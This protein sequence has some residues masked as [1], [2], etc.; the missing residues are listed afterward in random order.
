MIFFKLSTVTAGLLSA[1]NI[2]SDVTGLTPDNKLTKDSHQ[3]LSEENMYLSTIYAP[4]TEKVN[5]VH[6]SSIYSTPSLVAL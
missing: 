2:I 5:T 3:G 4:R 1:V 6:L